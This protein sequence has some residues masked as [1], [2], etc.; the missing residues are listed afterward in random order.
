[1]INPPWFQHA[2]VCYLKL[3]AY[4]VSNSPYHCSTNRNQL[5]AECPA[6]CG[7]HFVGHL[8]N[9][10]F[11]E[12]TQKHLAKIGFAEC[13]KKCTRQGVL[14]HTTKKNTWQTCL[15]AECIFWHL[16]NLHVCGVYFLA[17]GKQS[18]YWV[19]KKKNTQQKE[20]QITFWSSKFIQIK[21]TY[22]SKK[23]QAS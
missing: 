16:A 8:A 2:P 15:F 13:H 10:Q 14:W 20:I 4:H 17:L 5:F 1:M 18:F 19:L 23:Y 12:C 21:N 9:N 22:R 6:L 7:V 3:M 11:A